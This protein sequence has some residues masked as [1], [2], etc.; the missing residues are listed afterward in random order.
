M[1]PRKVVYGGGQSVVV[2]PVSVYV[3]L[4]RTAQEPVT[5]TSVP[6]DLL[7]VSGGGRLTD[8][9]TVISGMD[10]H[11]NQMVPV[12]TC[13]VEIISGRDVT[14]TVPS[15]VI[16]AEGQYSGRQY[17]NSGASFTIKVFGRSD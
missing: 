1:A 14:L 13:A 4:P 15:G 11:P 3:K 17:S 16:L 10:L 2:V 12:A 8:P 5:I 9:C 7:Y 6:S